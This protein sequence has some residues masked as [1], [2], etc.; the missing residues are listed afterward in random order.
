LDWIRH[1]AQ[2]QVRHNFNRSKN[3]KSFV[4]LFLSRIVPSTETLP[5]ANFI[6]QQ[7]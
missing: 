2:E 4:D 1:A 7:I 5:H 6:L 3:L